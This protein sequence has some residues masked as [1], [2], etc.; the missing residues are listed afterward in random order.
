MYWPYLGFVRE[1]KKIPVLAN[2]WLS[3]I[4]ELSLLDHYCK[5]DNL[6]PSYRCYHVLFIWFSKPVQENSCF[7]HFLTECYLW[8]EELS[9]SY[10][11]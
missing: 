7:E 5:D 6:T 4:S 11:C 8:A 1:Y 10:P 2:F 3:A 9:P